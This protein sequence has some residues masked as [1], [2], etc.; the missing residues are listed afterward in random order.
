M[1]KNGEVSQNKYQNE[2]N[3]RAEAK[4]TSTE[5]NKA[6]SNEV[7]DDV[8]KLSEMEN[9]DKA[10]DLLENG[11]DQTLSPEQRAEILQSIQDQAM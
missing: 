4:E 1:L 8:V 10:L 9:K 11:E 5:M 6:V 2:L 7:A 3:S